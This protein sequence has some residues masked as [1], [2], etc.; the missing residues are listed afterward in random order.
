MI[1]WIFVLTAFATLTACT[2]KVAD[3]AIPVSTSGDTQVDFSKFT[4][5][6]EPSNVD[7]TR[8]ADGTLEPDSLKKAFREKYPT[9]AKACVEMSKSLVGDY[10]KWDFSVTSWTLKDSEE[11]LT[12]Q[13]MIDKGWN[14]TYR[15]FPKDI[16]ATLDESRQQLTTQLKIGAESKAIVWDIFPNGKGLCTLLQDINQKDKLMN[17]WIAIQVLSKEEGKKSVD[18]FFYWFDS[19]HTYQAD[20]VV[21][22]ERKL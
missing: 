16:V 10:A 20:G 14:V 2:V 8:Q 3:P 18:A 15:L 4:G 5:E 21:S 9:E 6:S 12:N 17:D 1:K 13:E 19:N 7:V 22:L 11:K